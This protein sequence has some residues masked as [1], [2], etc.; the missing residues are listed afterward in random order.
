ME[1]T[2]YQKSPVAWPSPGN[3]ATNASP[4]ANRQTPCVTARKTNAHGRRQPPEYA[5]GLPLISQEAAAPKAAPG[6]IFPYPCGKTPAAP[7]GAAANFPLPRQENPGRPIKGR[8]RE[9]PPTRAG[10]HPPGKPLSS[11]NHPIAKVH[12]QNRGTLKKP[13]AKPQANPAAE[14]PPKIPLPPIPQPLLPPITLQPHP[15][16]PPV[17]PPPHP[18]PLPPHPVPFLS[19]PRNIPPQLGPFLPQPSLLLLIR[20]RLDP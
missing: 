12:P 17:T 10:K 1:T 7:S 5:I 6:R 3:R 20:R 13:T 14:S 2:G 18:N 8:R 9:F 16:I 4:T 11:P 19:Q 15:P